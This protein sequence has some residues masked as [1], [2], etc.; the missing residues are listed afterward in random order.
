MSVLVI[1][2]GASEL[3]CAHTLARTGRRVLV[4]EGRAEQEE[5]S[6]DRGWVPP[7][8][9]RELALGP[10]GP[11]TGLRTNSGQ[12]PSTGSG[13]GLRIHLPDPWAAAPLPG[14]GRLEL[15][16]DLT[17]S[18]E[19]I[20]RVS[21]RDAARWPEFCE[22]MSRLARLL[23][24]LYLQPPPDPMSHAIGDLAQL[25]V[26]G[27]RARRTGRQAIEDW[28]RLLPMSVADW[29]DDWFEND[30]L[31][32][33]LG[34][35]G[36]THLRQGPRSGGTAFVLL[37]HH[38]G[39]PAGVF[40]PPRS[41]LRQV[42]AGLPGVEIRRGAEV[43]R[44]DVRNG[45]VA[46][47]ALASG[48]ELPA[49]IVVSGADP[50]RTLLELTDPAWLDPEVT[51]TLKRVRCRGVVAR[52]RLALDRAPACPTLVVA[53]SLDYLEQAYDDAKYGRLSRRPFVEAVSAGAGADG[54]S[55]LEAHVQYA[56]YALADGEWSDER[57]RAL[58][59]LVRGILSQHLPDLGGTVVE[60]VLSPR[61]LEERYG[62]PEGQQHHAELALDQALWMRPVPALARYRTPIEG[63]Y[64]C[65]P[66]AHPGGSVS[67]VPG[68]N[69]ARAIRH[70]LRRRERVTRDPSALRHAQD[71]PLRTG[72]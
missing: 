31:K 39:S 57:C 33:V 29:L 52:V 25:A 62:Y 67:G 3:A 12:G 58:G 21:P 8:L 48:E 60:R 6:L 63:L 5:L 46:G 41:N 14:G 28:L 50:R 32:G 59:D 44:I 35:A 11:S 55:R 22:R 15:W 23:E 37:H 34:V 20:R 24:H 56:P 18:V 69:A 26:L 68:Y 51:R 13:Q 1:G 7:Q 16:R 54:R 42:L 30:A 9:V 43:A 65:G 36:V 61:D 4:L 72:W 47:V 45:R 27:F 53:P 38:V 66:G 71:R 2:A 64:L 19:A 70:D 49:S 40:R 10:S 17:R